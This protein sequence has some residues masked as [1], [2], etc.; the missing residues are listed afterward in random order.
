MGGRGLIT[1][2]PQFDTAVSQSISPPGK[3]ER[4]EKLTPYT[5][6]L[7]RRV[8]PHLTPNGKVLYCVKQHT[9]ITYCRV[10]AFPVSGS[11]MW[12]LNFIFCLSQFV[13]ALKKKLSPRHSFRQERPNVKLLAVAFIGRRVDTADGAICFICRPSVYKLCLLLMEFPAI[14]SWVLIKLTLHY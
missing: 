14:G 6:K 8:L 3:I 13:Q 5:L 12:E 4:K 10:K 1:A 11:V 2:S 7:L 9:H